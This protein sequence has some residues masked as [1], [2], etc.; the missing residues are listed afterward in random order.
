MGPPAFVAATQAAHNP[1][2]QSMVGNGLFNAGIAAHD[3]GD[4]KE[5]LAWGMFW[6]LACTPG[7][8]G[9]RPISP[10]GTTIPDSPIPEPVQIIRR[11]VGPEEANIAA[12]EGKIPNTDQFGRP[13]IVNVTPDEP[14]SSPS[15]VEEA[16]QVGEKDPSGPKQTP[17]HVITGDASKTTF[18]SGGNVEGGKGTTE[19]HTKET[20]PVINVEP[21]KEDNR[22]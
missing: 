16:Y 5:A 7:G 6:G 9:G 11:Y 21:L 13:K 20:I 22:G 3:G 18:I 8:S 1:Q 19:L 14:M 2:V 15:Q 12:T 4:P 10:K 17:T